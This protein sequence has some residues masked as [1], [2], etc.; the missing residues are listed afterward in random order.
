[1]LN[2]FML[3]R[4]CWKDCSWDPYYKIVQEHVESRIHSDGPR[5]PRQEASLRRV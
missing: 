5:D 3:R 2:F 1:V 4:A